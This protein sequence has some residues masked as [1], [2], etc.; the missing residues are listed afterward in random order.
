MRGKRVTI[1]EGESRWINF[2]YERLPNFCYSCGMLS[3]GIK[4]CPEGTANAYQNA[5]EFQ[6]GAW[7]R[8]EPIRR[9]NKESNS[10]GMERGPEGGGATRTRSE[11]E[12]CS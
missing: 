7:M 1:E 5:E 8:G 10:P 4:E 6:Y 9:G 3:H 11:T 12:N 2:R